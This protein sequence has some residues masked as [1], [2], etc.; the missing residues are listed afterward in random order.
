METCNPL[1]V[2]NNNKFPIPGRGLHGDETAVAR[3]GQDATSG[4][5]LTDTLSLGKSAHGVGYP[6]SQASDTHTTSARIPAI[7]HKAFRCFVLLIIFF[8]ATAVYAQNSVRHRIFR[9]GWGSGG[10]AIFDQD[11]KREWSLA[12]GDELSD[13]WML[14]DGGIVFSYSKRGKEAGIIRL[15]ANKKEQWRYIAPD[16]H[17][18]HSCQPIPGGGFLAGETAKDGMWM[19]EVDKDGKESK[20]IKV[21]DKTKDM[22]HTFRQVRKTPQG[23]YLAAIMNE[24]KTYE[25]DAAGQLIRTFPKGAFVAVRLPDG[26]T[27]V[28]SHNFVIEYDIAGKVVWETTKPDFEVLGLKVS[29]VCG[30]QRLPNGNTVITNVSHGKSIGSGDLV[31]A[32]E[33]T[34]EKRLVWSVPSAT[35]KGN[36]GALQ[37]LDIPGD[38]HRFEV[39]R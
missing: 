2:N 35:D 29:L 14:P 18:N 9:A 37:I 26:N 21:G 15:D 27:L 34:R 1:I 32:F 19:V 3:F 22:F 10:P 20:R 24:D 13:G 4:Y 12:N 16:K 39:L 30:L 17:D 11:L 36:M 33:I 8:A 31:R 5:I 28:S 6:F 7:A 23:T 25:W 38:V